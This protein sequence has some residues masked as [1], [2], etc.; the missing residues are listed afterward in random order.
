MSEPESRGIRAL[1]A[2]VVFLSALVW[3]SFSATLVDTSMAFVVPAPVLAPPLPDSVQDRDGVVHVHVQDPTGQPLIEASVT[4]F[5]IRDGQAFLVG[6]FVTDAKGKAV[7]R[8]IPR[9]EVWF[10]AEARGRA[11]TSAKVQVA[12]KPL[13]IKLKLRTAS[14]LEVHVVDD[15]RAPVANAKVS[16]RTGDP[17]PFIVTTDNTGIAT[18][19]RLGPSPWSLSVSAPG[20]E[21]TTRNAVS[22]ASTEVTLRKLGAFDVLVV[23][24]QGNAVPDATVMIAGPGLWPARQTTT[25]NEGHVML[26]GL[27]S[28]AYDLVAFHNDD[29]SVPLVGMSLRRGEVTP[30]K[31]ELGP[32]RRVTVKVVDG[33]EQDAA[34]VSGASVLLVESGVSSFPREALT[35]G[36]GTA[37]LG[38]ISMKSATVSA[39][40]DGF[41]PRTA[42]AVPPPDAN[43]PSPLIIPL[44]KG[45][46]LLGEVVDTRDFP[47]ASASVE[48]V[49]T[50]F[51]GMPVDAAPER[52]TFQAIHFAF[53]LQGPA[54]LIPAGEL[55]VMPGPIPGIPTLGG[56]LTGASVASSDPWITDTTGHF[57]AAPVPPGRLRALV[58]HPSY[59]EALSEAVSL[60]PGAVTTVKIVLHPGGILS[61]RVL[62]TH[63]MPVCGARVEVA[64]VHGTMVR[65]TLTL[66]DGSFSFAA[67]PG[68]VVVSLARADSPE[69]VVLRKAVEIPD[70]ERREVTLVMPEPREP[71]VVRVV[72]D[73]GAPVDAAE[74]LMLSLTKEVP[75]RTTLFARADGQVSFNDAAGIHARIEVT[76][77]GF[78]PVIKTFEKL[79][80]EVTIALKQGAVITGEIN[81]RGGLVKGAKV[82]LY[83]GGLTRHATSESDGSFTFKDLAPGRARLVVRAKGFGRHELAITIPERDT[84]GRVTQIERIDLVDAGSIEGVVVNKDG[85]P[86]VGARVALDAVPAFLPVGGVP[87]GIAVTDSRGRFVLDDVGEGDHVVVEAFAPGEGRGVARDVVVQARRATIDV[88]IVL[89]IETSKEEPSSAG[90]VAIT[91]EERSPGVVTIRS[92]AEASEAERAE[93]MPGDVILL[94]GEERPKSIEQARRLLAGPVGDDVL[95]KVRRESEDKT[96][97]V[98]R[99]KIRR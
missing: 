91:L 51:S 82:T 16:I 59:V 24:A 74:V 14:S 94:V 77:P 40:A 37:T 55:G 76:C 97:R 35:L 62:D 5:A 79:E 80:R 60:A 33:L 26:R 18:A 53:A 75:L 65:S 19:T 85:D 22:G 92:V 50:D 45:A 99:E 98:A 15:Q 52:S 61:G 57:R 1:R 25:G 71:V 11:R 46:T 39:R 88:K 32:G 38:P 56:G 86:V 30:L 8:G 84:Q 58:R 78:A 67:M 21:S 36:D 7:V 9:G 2:L 87:V 68:D 64:A 95:L 43:A 81:S 49:G 20:Y 42:M 47:V 29:A 90:G 13:A 3:L 28:G 83:S 44:L 66:E 12:D 69:N 72:D 89:D 17:L 27:A 10:L 6:S 41:V 63:D 4:A 70:G 34:P 23:D 93:L 31:I 96:I 54:P 73:H 48:V